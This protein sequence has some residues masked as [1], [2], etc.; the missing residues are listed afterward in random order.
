MQVP[1]VETMGGRTSGAM[2]A[3]KVRRC[4]RQAVIC[5]GVGT[6]PRKRLGRVGVAGRGCGSGGSEIYG[7]APKDNR[8][9]RAKKKEIRSSA[10]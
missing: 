5:G 6:R 2:I 1:G 3:E 9:G 8:G 4:A 10:I 7:G